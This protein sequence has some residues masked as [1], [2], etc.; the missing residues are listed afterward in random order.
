MTDIDIDFL[1]AMRNDPPFTSPR[2]NR[3]HSLIQSRPTAFFDN[4]KYFFIPRNLLLSSRESKI[5][6]FISDIP[7]FSDVK[8]RREP[9]PQADMLGGPSEAQTV[10][11]TLMIG[12]LR[13]KT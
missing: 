5:L 7:F 3:I 1:T 8:G 2:Q 12:S 10:L 11:E 9:L 4:T 13:L 6:L